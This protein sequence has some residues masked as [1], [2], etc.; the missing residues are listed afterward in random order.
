LAFAVAAHLEP[1]ILLVDEV[2]AVGD[3]AFQKKCLGKMGDVAKEGRTVLFVSHNVAAIRHMCPRTMLIHNGQIVAFDNTPSI[4]GLYERTWIES[5]SQKLSVGTL[6]EINSDPRQEFQILKIEMLDE[7]GRTKSV[8]ST[9]DR[10]KFRIHYYA[11]CRLENGS[12]VFQVR[13]LEGVR[14]LLCSTQPD[15]NI[16]MTIEAGK[17][18]VDCEFPSWPLAGGRYLIGAALAIP[19]KEWLT[20]LEDMAL[21]EVEGRDVLHSG[22]IVPHMSRALMVIPHSWLIQRE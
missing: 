7:N 8:L 16:P 10:V 5:R 19:N 15:S 12:A 22:M 1:E 2:L 20:P 14:L 9:W 4:V 13:S 6:Y 3:A 11:K 21:L 17:H 18:Y